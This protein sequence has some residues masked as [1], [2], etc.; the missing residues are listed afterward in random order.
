[1]TAMNYQILKKHART[2]LPSMT[3]ACVTLAIKGDEYVIGALVR[4]R[5]LRLTGTKH[6]IACMITDDVSPVPQ[7]DLRSVFDAARL[8]MWWSITK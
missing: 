4:A 3:C 5:S 1:V 2:E 8:C 7:A 6:V